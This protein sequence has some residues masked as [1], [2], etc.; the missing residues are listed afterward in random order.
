MFVGGAL[1]LATTASTTTAQ[2][3]DP[4]PKTLALV[5]AEAEFA[6]N[7]L[8]GAR[9]QG[10]EYGLKVLYD[11]VYPPTTVNFTPILK[12]VQA[13]SPDLVFGASYPSDTV[14]LIRTAQ[15]IKLEPK[16][17]GGAM[18][19]TQY[20]TIKQQ[21]NEALSFEQYV[22]EPTVKFPGIEAMLK[23]YQARAVQQGVD[24]L[25]F[26]VP[27]F[28]C[29]ALQILGEAVTRTGGVDQDK[30]AAYMHANTFDTMVGAIAF[31]ADGE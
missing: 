21:L 27:P 29:S 19:G 11:R 10:K 23:T 28:V 5:G 1:A 25:G 17:F 30:L 9:N 2:A 3:A 31:G 6:Q 7:A 18:V 14:G 20:T 13:T 4:K 16:M 22:P 26:Y 24:A 8:E 15:E 12:A